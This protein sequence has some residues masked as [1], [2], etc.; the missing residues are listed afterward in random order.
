MGAGELKKPWVWWLYCGS[1]ASSRQDLITHYTQQGWWRH[2]SLPPSTKGANQRNF[3]SQGPVGPC[4]DYSKSYA[5]SG[6]LLVLS[7]WDCVLMPTSPSPSQYTHRCSIA[8]FLGHLWVA[9][10]IL[11][12]S[13]LTKKQ[14]DPLRF[15]ILEIGD[16]LDW[17]RPMLLKL[18]SLSL[19]KEPWQVFFP[20]ITLLPMAL[21]CISISQI[22]QWFV[23][24][25]FLSLHSVPSRND[26]HLLGSNTT[27]WEY[28]R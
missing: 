17:A 24:L 8:F 21:L 6:Y 2:L 12:L 18:F 14:R 11:D 27:Y 5:D 16:C 3:C 28:M 7:E 13:S 9:L 22:L 15:Q 23:S 20:L 4:A 19:P 1:W 25:S 10:L 26:F